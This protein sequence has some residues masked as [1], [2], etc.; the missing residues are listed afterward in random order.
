MYAGLNKHDL[1]ALLLAA[2]EELRKRLKTRD[3]FRDHWRIPVEDQND[4]KPPKRIVEDLV[5]RYLKRKYQD[6]DDAVVVLKQASLQAVEK[7][8]PQFAKFVREL[9][10]L[11][12]GRDPD[13]A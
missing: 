8:C 4:T 7:A 9:R 10:A 11:T 6:T 2:P 3:A 1:E 5:R 12:E 13:S